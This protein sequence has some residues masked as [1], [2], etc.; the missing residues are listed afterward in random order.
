MAARSGGGRMAKQRQRQQQW[1]YN[2]NEDGRR[3]MLVTNCFPQKTEPETRSWMQ[4]VYLRSDSLKQEK[5]Y[6]VRL[7]WQAAGSELFATVTAEIRGGL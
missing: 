1:Q 3:G 5:E 2:G 4:V 7:K 6:N